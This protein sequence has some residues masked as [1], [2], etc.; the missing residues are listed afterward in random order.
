MDELALD[1][2][3]AGA[4]DGLGA[5]G[6]GVEDD[7]GVVGGEGHG[8][9]GGEVLGEGGVGGFAD[10]GEDAEGVEEAWCHSCQLRCS[11]VRG[12]CRHGSRMDAVRGGDE[13]SPCDSPR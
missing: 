5:G 6:G 2:D 3:G 13:G 4:D 10:G 1:E 11:S 9:H 8:E 7:E 12:S